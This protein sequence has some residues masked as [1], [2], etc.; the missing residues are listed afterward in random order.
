M[1]HLLPVGNELLAVHV[2]VGEEIVLWVQEEARKWIMEIEF[3]QQEN[4]NEIALK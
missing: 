1:S 4:Q 3:N 2:K